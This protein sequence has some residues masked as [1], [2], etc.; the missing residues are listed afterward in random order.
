MGCRLCLRR[1]LPQPAPPAPH[2]TSQ[3]ARAARTER[4]E[5]SVGGCNQAMKPTAA[6]ESLTEEQGV[7]NCNGLLGEGLATLTAG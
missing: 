4:R 3:K 1:Q 2:P 7:A 5:E 6:P